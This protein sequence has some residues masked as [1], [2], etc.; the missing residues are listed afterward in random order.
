MVQFDQLTSQCF[1]FFVLRK[2]RQLLNLIT[3]LVCSFPFFKNNQVLSKLP[4]VIGY[5]CANDVCLLQAQLDQRPKHDIQQICH[6][7]LECKF[8]EVIFSCTV[9]VCSFVELFLT[10]CAASLV[11]SVSQAANPREAKIP[12]FVG[13]AKFKILILHASLSED[14]CVLPVL[15]FHWTLV[16]PGLTCG[17]TKG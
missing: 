5:F 4:S 6:T 16:R 12:S 14:L 7:T 9:H 10:C 1:Y 15:P 8:R 2:K 3:S 13:S 11:C 17:L